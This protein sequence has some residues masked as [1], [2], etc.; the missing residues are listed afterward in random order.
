MEINSL[1]DQNSIRT[2]KDRQ[3]L[4][5]Y[6]TINLTVTSYQKGNIPSADG[7]LAIGNVLVRNY[8]VCVE[9]L[10]TALPA[11]APTAMPTSSYRAVLA[12]RP[13]PFR[14]SIDLST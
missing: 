7:V 12:P 9:A 6:K 3:C 13:R 5:A 4:P 8:A 1:Q 11:G 2:I 10:G 14:R